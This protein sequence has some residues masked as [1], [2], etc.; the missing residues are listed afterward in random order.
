M[1]YYEVGVRVVR[2]DLVHDGHEVAAGG[3][4]APSARALEWRP[5][6]AFHDDTA[7]HGLD[8]AV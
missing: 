3:P 4:E 7:D 1:A 6:Q 2:A 5:D 8:R